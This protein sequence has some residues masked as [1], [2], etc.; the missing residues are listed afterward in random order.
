LSEVWLLNFLRSYCIFHPAW[1]HLD[2]SVLGLQSQLH[3][4]C[5]RLGEL[6][7]KG[8]NCTRLWQ[9]TDAATTT[10]DSVWGLNASQCHTSQSSAS[11][12]AASQEK[13]CCTWCRKKEHRSGTHAAV[14]SCDIVRKRKHSPNPVQA[15]GLMGD[16]ACLWR[17]NSDYIIPIWGSKHFAAPVAA[18][19]GASA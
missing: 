4:L 2:R 6:L 16:L 5:T 8:S 18:S 11:V 1:I 17:W 14:H 15:K 19:T 9:G 12:Q 3:N 13:P 7:C 10:L